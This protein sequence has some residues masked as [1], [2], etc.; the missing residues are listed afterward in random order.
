MRRKKEKCLIM[1]FIKKLPQVR[2]LVTDADGVLTNGQLYYSDRGDEIKAF[3][4]QDGEGLKQIKQ[5]GIRT[6]IISGRSS[7]SLRR[8]AQ[9]LAIDDV[10]M[11]VNDK[12]AVL[13]EILE[14]HVISAEETLYI[15][16][17]VGDLGA[18]LS[19]GLRVAVADA[20]D[21]VKRCADYVTAK[22][23]G[24]GAVR[25]ICDLIIS[26]K[27]AP[28]EG[29]N[30]MGK[31][32]HVR[33]IKIGGGLPLVLFAGPCVIESRDHALQMAEA[34]KKISEQTGVRFVFKSSYDKA[35]RSSIDS[36]RG[37]GCE[38]GLRTLEEVQ[39][40]VGVPVLSDVH[41]VNEVDLVASILDVLQI[42]AFLC[43]QTDLLV[44]AGKTGKPVKVKKGQ[45]MAPWDMTNVIEKIVSTGNEQILLTERGSSFGYN[46]LVVDMTSIPIMKETGFPVVFDATHSVQQPGG[47]GKNSGGRREFVGH[48]ARAAAAA[49]IDALFM[50]VHNRPDE[51]L[52]DGPNMVNLEQLELI[53]GTVVQI[54][55]VV[56]NNV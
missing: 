46:N 34:I 37:P 11:G 55:R 18:L 50:E 45:F 51:A 35:N 15:G 10:H 4:V 54:D 21:Q 23:G 52:C 16:D 26:E 2:L 44:S 29:T 33:D 25:E 27:E 9:E 24:A 41:C 1:N 14:T 53:L 22:P 5:H 43:R 38:Q 40:E 19:V 8:R 39:R 3:N 49:G 12:L 32:V 20:H 31:I 36:Y 47:L 7:E 56:K 28:S 17:D 48:L 42:P 13:K 30:V 6:A